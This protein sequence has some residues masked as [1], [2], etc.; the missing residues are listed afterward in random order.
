[1]H[2]FFRAF[3]KTIVALIVLIAIASLTM[4]Q[5]ATP[6]D[7]PVRLRQHVR[8]IASAEHNTSTPAALE[9]AARYIETTLAAEG[10]QVRRH[11]FTYAG[12]KV[13]NLEVS[14][15]A[16]QPRKEPERIF[17]V[18][19]HYDSAPGA[20]GA[21]DNGSGS[22]ALIE[23]ARLLKDL[24]P[25]AGSELKFVF[26]VNEEPPYF[27]SEGMGSLR[28]AGELRRRGQKV[29][30]ALILET[31]GYYSTA[32]DSQRYPPG[33]GLE[34][35]YPNAGNFIAF[36]GT[37]PSSALVANT[38]AAFRAASDFPCEGLAAPASVPGVTLSDH[39]SYNRFGYPALM[40]TDTAFLRYPH[41]HTE[42]D[43]PDKLDYASMAR[44]V[45]GLAKAV[46]AIT[47]STH[48]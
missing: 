33:F 39:S 3:W 2:S 1:M 11:E 27:M 24:R 19:A 21:N 4:G 26:F 28:H 29:E 18:G 17:I 46:S 47:S 38:L 37:T 16:T 36:V 45:A 15:P 8:A 5:D 35:S 44:I 31:I 22:A 12:H 23:L 20:P 7:L 48:K 14:V 41:Y 6:T 43:T 9:Q 34:K 13:R 40:I 10:Y 25:G 32:R 42:N 30:A